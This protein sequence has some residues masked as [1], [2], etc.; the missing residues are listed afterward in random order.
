MLMQ[1]DLLQEFH[2]R[3]GQVMESESQA[4]KRAIDVWQMAW[5]YLNYFS[6]T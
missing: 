3:D 5:R 2:F 6:S 1:I 4:E